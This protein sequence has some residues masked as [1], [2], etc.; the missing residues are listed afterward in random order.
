MQNLINV[1]HIQSC[2][3]AD[4]GR[5]DKFYKGSVQLAQKRRK[6]TGPLHDEKCPMSH[7]KKRAL[8]MDTK[9]PDMNKKG[10]TH[11]FFLFTK[12]GGGEPLLGG[13]G[14]CPPPRNFLQIVQFR[15]F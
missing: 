9:A 1:K 6:G 12:G 10:P 14:A 4:R 8:Y 11:R 13:L 2:S 15:A 7:K 3:L 5:L